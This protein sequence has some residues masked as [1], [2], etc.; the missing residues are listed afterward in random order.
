MTR[1]ASFVSL[2]TSYGFKKES[3]DSI[4][5]FTGKPAQVKVSHNVKIEVTSEDQIDVFDRVLVESCGIPIEWKE[6]L[7]RLVTSWTRRGARNY[8]AYVEGNPVGTTTL[9]SCAR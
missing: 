2:L 5:V 8:L 4:M 3:D 6:A 9:A 1:P 7:D